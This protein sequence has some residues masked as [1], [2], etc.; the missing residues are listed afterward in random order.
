MEQTLLKKWRTLPPEKQQE[1][2]DFV[3][4]LASRSLSSNTQPSTSSSSKAK[5]PLNL[6]E[7]LRKARAEIVASEVPLM[8]L[9]QLEQEKASRRG[10]YQ[11][12]EQ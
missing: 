9:E 12:T 2:I 7:K 11:E 1:V 10:G 6:G 5:A 8:N 4:F 3:D